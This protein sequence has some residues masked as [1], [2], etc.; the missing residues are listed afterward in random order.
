MQQLTSVNLQISYVGLI[1]KNLGAFCV[2]HHIKISHWELRT[3][4]DLQ[5]TASYRLQDYPHTEHRF[6]YK[7]IPIKHCLNAAGY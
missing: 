3:E 2:T 5:S 7:E 6:L 4:I 1:G